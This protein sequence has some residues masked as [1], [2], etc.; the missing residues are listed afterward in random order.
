MA[1]CMPDR[2]TTKG[3]IFVTYSKDRKNTYAVSLFS[4]LL[5]QYTRVYKEISTAHN[6][7][8]KCRSSVLLK[9]IIDNLWTGAIKL[10]LLS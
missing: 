10:T 8:K 7:N 4:S 6:Q 5:L 1:S 9:I 3:A 2:F